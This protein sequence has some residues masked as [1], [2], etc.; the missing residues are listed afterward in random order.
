MHIADY[1]SRLLKVI[2][3]WIEGRNDI[4]TVENCIDGSE[5]GGLL[6]STRNGWT[7][8]MDGG[9]CACESSKTAK[10]K[11]L[12]PSNDV[13][14]TTGI[15]PINEILLWHNAIRR[16]LNEIAKEAK[17]IQLSGDFSDLSAFEGRLQF[18]AEVC[19]FHRY[20]LRYCAVKL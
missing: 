13:P 14:A 3:T 15:C 6:D 7:Q 4:D 8:Q 17:K 19:I 18:I 5:V 2:F 12:E 20:F 1:S 16:E 10:R 9:K 11:Y